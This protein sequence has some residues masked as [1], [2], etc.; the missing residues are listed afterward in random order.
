MGTIL[1]YS[2][3]FSR[4][5]IK[6]VQ[7]RDNCIRLSSSIADKQLGR[8]HKTLVK[9]SKNS[10]IMTVDEVWLLPVDDK[11]VEIQVSIA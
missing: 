9:S 3:L 1:K 7:F 11:M 8:E 4:T 6:N 5:L 2:R 10:Q